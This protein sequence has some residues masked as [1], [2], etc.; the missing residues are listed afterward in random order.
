MFVRLDWE[1]LP[2]TNTLAYYDKKIYGQKRF[3]TLGPGLPFQ[4]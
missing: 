3:I 2:T 1:S 4:A